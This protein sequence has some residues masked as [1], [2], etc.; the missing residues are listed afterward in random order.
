M[1]AAPWGNGWTRDRPLILPPFGVSAAWVFLGGDR[2]A[3]RRSLYHCESLAQAS[4]TEACVIAR[5]DSPL[6]SARYSTGIRTG[7]SSWSAVLETLCRGDRSD[8]RFNPGRG[9]KRRNQ[10][11]WGIHC[12]RAARAISHPWTFR[13]VRKYRSS[14]TR[15]TSLW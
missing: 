4:G 11:E 15:N 13:D 1:V 8:L 2:N 9:G 7:L 3:S 10:Y 5:S 14:S 12:E 6:E